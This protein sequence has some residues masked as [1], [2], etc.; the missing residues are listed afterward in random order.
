M[1][2]CVSLKAMHRF[3]IVGGACLG[4][5]VLGGCGAAD[6]D[7][8]SAPV[9]ASQI[10]P[11][12]SVPRENAPLERSAQLMAKINL[13]RQQT[14]GQSSNVE[15]RNVPYTAALR[16]A[17]YLNTIN[18]SDVVRGPTGDT[19]AATVNLDSTNTLPDLREESVVPTDSG[20]RPFPALFTHPDLYS[21][22]AAVVGSP[23]VLNLSPAALVMEDYVFNGNIP[24]A[25]IAGGGGGGGGAGGGGGGA[26]STN[27][28]FRGFNLDQRNAADPTR[29]QFDAAD[30]LWYSMH[31]RILAARQ[32][33]RY[34]GYAQVDDLNQ[35]PQRNFAP[36]YPLFGGRFK[37]VWVSILSSDIVAQDGF[38]PN[39]FNTNVNPYGLDTDVQSTVSYVGPPIH[40][41]SAVAE[42]FLITTV[43]GP[44]DG[45]TAYPGITVGFAKMKNAPDTGAEQTPPPASASGR[46]VRVY[47]KVPGGGTSIFFSGNM[48]SDPAYE[49][50]FLSSSS[51]PKP[52]WEERDGE[53]FIV[54]TFP[55]EPNTFR[56]PF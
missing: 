46:E 14:F 50:N 49:F 25:S 28:A 43:Q 39:D 51:N 33:V 37:G 10:K 20:S 45:V 23:D 1:S 54:P 5:A 41:T 48:G 47:F 56:F 12:Q 53:L 36:P 17:I 21:R 18:S 42:P 29:Y 31:G 22:V 7:P 52:G 35:S 40:V 13:Y 16:H 26:S 27:S 55:L 6:G 32:G 9:S 8:V 15:H 30:N 38:W 44:A 4:I 24:L 11:P 34:M 19:G 2:L 3:A